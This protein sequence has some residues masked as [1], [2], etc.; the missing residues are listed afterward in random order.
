MTLATCVTGNNWPYQYYAYKLLD[1]GKMH[2]VRQVTD[3]KGVIE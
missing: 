2:S 3:A 1:H